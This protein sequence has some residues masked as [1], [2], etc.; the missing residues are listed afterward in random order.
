MLMLIF[1]GRLLSEE[2]ETPS[3]AHLRTGLPLISSLTP[4]LRP[5]AR[6]HLSCRILIYRA[7]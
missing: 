2:V 4:P 5:P 6:G 7:P 1:P 3:P